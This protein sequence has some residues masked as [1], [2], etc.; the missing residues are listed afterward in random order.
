ML[1]ERNCAS[2]CDS[3]ATYNDYNLELWKDEQRVYVKFYTY[4]D[5]SEDITYWK[6]FM[7][8]CTQQVFS[9]IYSRFN[10]KNIFIKTLLNF[11]RWNSQLVNEYE[12][13]K[14]GRK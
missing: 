6:K 4:I 12:W 9:E 7:Y 8:G 11:E 13:S 2:H 3:K 10:M 5:V 14:D 1:A